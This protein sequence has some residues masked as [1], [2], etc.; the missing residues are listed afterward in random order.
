MLEMGLPALKIPQKFE[1]TEKT[2]LGETV[3]YRGEERQ[4]KAIFFVSCSNV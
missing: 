1:Q 2:V 4:Y 3:V